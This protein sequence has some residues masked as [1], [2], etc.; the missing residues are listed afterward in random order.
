MQTKK[1]I[2]NLLNR[3]RAVLKKCHLLN[4]FGTLALASAFILGGAASAMSD[5][6]QDTLRTTHS[7]NGVTYGEPFNY[8][9]NFESKITDSTFSGASLKDDGVGG[10]VFY[11]NYAPGVTTITNSAFNGNVVEN[12]S[13]DADAGAFFDK[14][15]TIDLNNVTFT[16]NKATVKSADAM[17]WGGAIYAD[18]KINKD[19]AGNEI[20]GEAILNFNVTKDMTYSG[21]TIEVQNT[22]TW[23]DGYGAI[24]KSSGGFLFLDRSSTANFNVA[25]GATLTIGAED[26]SGHMDSIAS[27]LSLDESARAKSSTLVKK[28]GGTLTVNSQLNDFT[29]MWLS[30]KAP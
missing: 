22:S 24:S 5:T 6:V 21:N 14:G 16:D 15:T 29:V 17:A 12:D 10:G 25:D 3:Y 13:L 28:G 11:F 7:L 9:V 30:R 27:S 18:A 4:T 23:V 1:A 20:Y 26:A 19:K 2:G 8:Y